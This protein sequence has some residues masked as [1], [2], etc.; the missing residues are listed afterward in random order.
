MHTDMGYW[1][2]QEASDTV[3]GAK[4]RHAGGGKNGH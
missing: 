1:R 4:K 2:K 3:K